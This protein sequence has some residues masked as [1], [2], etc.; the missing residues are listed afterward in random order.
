MTPDFPPGFAQAT[1]AAAISNRFLSSTMT[2]APPYPAIP[3]SVKITL[4]Q[5]VDCRLRR[6]SQSLDN[7]SVG[8]RFLNLGT[9]LVAQRFEVQ[10]NCN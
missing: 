4:L 3:S 6:L 8:C 7:G 9:R 2:A 5:V 1:N 10:L